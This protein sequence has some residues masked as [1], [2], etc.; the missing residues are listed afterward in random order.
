MQD[1]YECIFLIVDLH[2]LTVQQVPAE[3]RHTCLSLAAQYIAAGIDPKEHRG[4]PIS[5][6][7]AR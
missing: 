1:D 2:A 7:T 3:L 5:C 4:H 6:P